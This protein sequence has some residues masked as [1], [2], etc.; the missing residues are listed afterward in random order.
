MDKTDNSVEINYPENVSDVGKVFKMLRTA[1]GVS[2]RELSKR[3]NI[4]VPTLH[5]W[6]KLEKCST[7]E[8]FFDTLRELGV[9]VTFSI[10]NEEDAKKK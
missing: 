7:L 1:Q 10:K 8:G 6:E 9:T 5:R 4:T 3:V 2:I